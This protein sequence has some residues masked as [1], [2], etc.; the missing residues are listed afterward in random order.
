M[1]QSL[2]WRS[3]LIVVVLASWTW[4]IFPLRDRDYMATFKE[5]AASR[6]EEVRKEREDAQKRLEALRKQLESK[7]DDRKLREKEQELTKKL[8]ESERILKE[9]EELWKRVEALRKEHPDMPPYL[10]LKRAASG[11]ER[12]PP[13]H[14]NQFIHIAMQPGAS[15]NQ[16]LTYV[17]RKSAGKL[18]LG[19]DLRGGTEFII[20]FNASEAPKDRPL[21]EVR[22][23][24]I[25]ILRNRV[26]RMGV[27]EP[28][29]KPIGP[30][31]ISLRMPSVSEADKAEIR[32]TI[33][34]TAKLTFHLVHKRSDEL[35]RKFREDPKANPLPPGWI[36]A[37]METERNGRIVT[38]GLV[39]KK[40]PERIRG[41]DV[42]RAFP[43]FNQFGNYSVILE[44]NGSGA[45]AFAAVTK[46]HI[47]DRLAVV[48]DGR[49]YSAP[50]IREAITGGRAEISGS[51]TPQEAKQLAVVLSCGNLP[52][53]IRIDSEFGTDPTL[54]RDS[55]RSGIMAAAWGMI[56]VVLFM[57][58]Y[59]RFAGVVAVMALCANMILILGTLTLSSATITLPGI[60]GIVLTI[61]MAV[62][63]NVLIF[64]RIREELAK[65]KSL[66]NAIS[67]GYRRA[68]VTILDSNLTTLITA[69]ILVKFGSGTV[70]GFGVT[71]SIGII[72][73]MFSALF[74]TRVVFDWFLYM[75]WLKR[76]RMLSFFT[77]PSVNFL[78]FRNAAFGL[79][80][81][82]ILISLVTAGMR[83]RDALSIDFAGGTT[84]TLQLEKGNPPDISV[85]REI[86]AEAGYKDSRVGYKFSPVEK[87]R[88]LEIT[89][90]GVSTGE[91]GF[92]PEKL[93]ARINQAVKNAVFRHVRT[94]SVGA[95]V[96]RQFQLKAIRAGILAAIAIVL[97]VSFRFEFAYGVASV[98]ALI[99]DVTIAAGIY[100][101]AGR[102]ISLPVLAALLTIMGYSLNDTIVVFD[103][104]REGLTL[105]KDRA[106]RDIINISVNETLSRTVL[107]S[108][109]TLLVVLTLLVFGGGAI[110]DFAFVMFV[111]V[112]VGTYSSIFVASA[113]ISTWH[114]HVRGV[115]D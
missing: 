19:L 24:I 82:L 73:S 66:G 49:V 35:V 27:V 69:F 3:V 50:V 88:M 101:L 63:A 31:S 55:V 93:T 77:N 112:I 12:R 22:D 58:V 32:N 47:G 71:L 90:R 15:N 14:L 107:T 29:I 100:I 40:Q 81:V 56:L 52:V 21:E 111:G 53:S 72:A 91:H 94:Y 42:A 65:G 108:L 34:Q 89:L 98:I 96:G 105:Y 38:E 5:L 106:Y 45:A 9:Y 78:G 67:A 7:K 11:D 2:I 26:D 64:E 87:T 44:F 114:R 85:L 4:S 104:I 62:D 20:G 59:Y 99:H 10:L 83:G 17:R 8:K 79:S 86:L 115:Q 97:Y 37:E 48:L 39:I 109:T 92:D 1:K 33:R 103:R 16:I 54:G 18:H 102:Q 80:G 43:T 51:F 61:G 75:G 113:I 60:A 74:M 25:E 110:N 70:R 57:V 46:E 76:L 23:Q 28:E 41:E 36:Y 84:V 68:F 13:I 30:T 95:L 6:I